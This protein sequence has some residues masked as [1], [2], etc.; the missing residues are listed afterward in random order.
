MKISWGVG[1]AVL[2]I[3]FMVVVL[4]T[5]AFSTTQDVN[6]VTEDY[7]EKELEYQNQLDKMNRANALPE[8]L[9]VKI[10]DKNIQI[11]YPS[12][13]SPEFLTGTILF[14]R[15]TSGEEDFELP[16]QPDVHGVQTVLTEKMSK[17]VWKVKVDWKASASEYF[18][19]KIVMVN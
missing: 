8:K 7:Y 10:V 11:K 12:M 9:E 6:L 2:Y 14:Y 16:V 5:V 13:F 1:I 18:N 3:G 17:G 19:E 4:G 15:P